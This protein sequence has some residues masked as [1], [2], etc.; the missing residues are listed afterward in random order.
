MKLHDLLR[1]ALYM[2][3]PVF[4]LGCGQGRAN[5]AAEVPPRPEVIREVDVNVVKVNRP[6]HFPLVSAVEHK[7]LPELTVTGV[8]SPDVSRNVP[9]ISLASGRIVEIRARLGDSV[10]KGQLLLRVQSA[11][12]SQ[13]FPDYR[14][15]V[16]D[17][18]LAHAQ[19]ERAK[20]L[21]DKGAIARKDVE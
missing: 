8:V 10:A 20:L 1:A 19:L 21:Y 7:A 2:S 17:E 12:V 11:D 18:T 3:T 15:A 6:D 4:V 5:P 13:A 14:Q 9:V 16:A